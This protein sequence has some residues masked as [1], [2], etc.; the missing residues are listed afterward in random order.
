MQFVLFYFFPPCSPLD[1]PMLL[2]RSW[3]SL[4]ALPKTIFYS[5]HNHSFRLRLQDLECSSTITPRTTGF[6]SAAKMF[7]CSSDH[8]AID[9]ANS[10]VFYTIYFSR[11]DFLKSCERRLQSV[12]RNNQSKTNIWHKSFYCSKYVSRF[13]QVLL[14]AFKLEMRGYCIITS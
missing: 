5:T 12:H 2:G 1:A 11:H 6:A 4:V 13:A 10:T 8:H 14:H 3:T 7:E 9:S